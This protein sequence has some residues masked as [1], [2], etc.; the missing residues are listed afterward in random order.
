LLIETLLVV[1]IFMLSL[2]LYRLWRGTESA[3]VELAFSKALQDVG[4]QS[5]IGMLTGLAMDIRKNQKSLDQMLTAPTSRGAFGEISLENILKDQLPPDMYGIRK[6]ALDG[7]IPDAHIK[8]TVGTI[9]IDSKFPLTN[10][11]RMMETRDESAKREY[12]GQFLRDVEGHLRKVAEDYVCPEHDSADFAFAYIP[13]EGVYWYLVT[14]GYEL[15]RDYTKQG[16]QVVSPLTLSHKIELIRAG[17]H[18][19]KLSEEAAKIEKD[20]RVLATRFNK[21]DETWSTLYGTHLRHAKDR[22]EDFDNEWNR[23][24]DEFRRIEALS[25]D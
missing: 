19:R 7:K 17:V 16:V 14:E 8:S 9:C 4:L 1:V 18:A 3:G 5:S 15:L 13:S 21:V 10:Y 25:D 11:R 22:S 20:I 12:G 24:R 6:R 2:V 23:L